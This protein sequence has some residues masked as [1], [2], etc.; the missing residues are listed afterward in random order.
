[1]KKFFRKIVSFLSMLFVDLEAWIHEHVQPSIE[2]VERLKKIVD[3]PVANIITALI[4]GDWD[5]ALKEAFSQRLAKAIDAMHITADIVNE[6]DWTAKV[7]KTYQYLQTLSKPMRAAIY[8]KLAAELAKES[9]GSE[10]VKGHAVDLLVQMQ[11]SK[12][13]EDLTEADLPA[14]DPYLEKRLSKVF[15]GQ[16]GAG[17]GTAD[18]NGAA[19]PGAGAADPNAGAQP[20]VG[21]ADPIAN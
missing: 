8:K 9:G 12:L 1:M 6:P 16:L 17:A 11:Y 20:G 18:P 21:A 10:K 15:A 19:Q 3:S 5:N 4:P 2:A 13:K 7:I 14:V